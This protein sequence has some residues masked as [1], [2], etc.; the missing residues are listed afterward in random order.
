M[1][2]LPLLT[3]ASSFLLLPLPARAEVTVYGFFG[4]TTI[5]PTNPGAGATALGAVAPTTTTF[6][7]APGPPSYTELAAYNDVYMYPPAIPSPAPPTQFAI[8]VPTDAGLMSGLSIKQQG[9]FF[10][11]S[12]E[13]S[14]AVQIS[15]CVLFLSWRA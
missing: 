13:M 11:F 7:T 8:G 2:P 10:G 4:Q 6:V 9:T 3:L 5:D 14:V 15:E 1:V 12:I